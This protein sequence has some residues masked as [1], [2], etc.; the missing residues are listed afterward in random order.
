V[1]TIIE[2]GPCDSDKGNSLH[3]RVS[4][5]IGK[6]VFINLVFRIMCYMTHKTNF[7]HEMP[8]CGSEYI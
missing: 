8:D 6:E 2:K 5:F 4:V 1:K 3:A 7:V